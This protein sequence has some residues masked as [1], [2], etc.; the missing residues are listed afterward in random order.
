M[1]FHLGRRLPATGFR[2]RLKGGITSKCQGNVDM[3]LI[4]K[5]S[6][7]YLGIQKGQIIS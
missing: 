6:N 4:G 2:R 7:Y 1:G 3:K 5:S